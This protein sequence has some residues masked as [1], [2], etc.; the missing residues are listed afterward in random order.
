[1][2]VFAVFWLRAPAEDFDRRR[3]LGV[4]VENLG[5]RCM[6]QASITGRLI[7]A[8]Q[9]LWMNGDIK[10]SAADVRVEVDTIAKRGSIAI[11]RR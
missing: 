6:C 3:P 4:V 10:R 5:G 11:C 1:M 9:H 2:L 7:D 8:R